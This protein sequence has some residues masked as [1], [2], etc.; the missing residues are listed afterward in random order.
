M[1]SWLRSASK[2]D[3]NEWNK[4]YPGPYNG[5]F[6][7][8]SDDCAKKYE[9][10]W[11]PLGIRTLMHDHTWG[12]LSAFRR[13]WPKS[14]LDANGDLLFD[15]FEVVS[16]SPGSPADGN[17]Q[18]G[19]LLIAMDGDLFRTALALR[20]QA[21]L[22]KFQETRGLE[23]DAGEKLD[24][25][26][27]RGKVSFDVIRP[28]AEGTT[29]TLNGK[30]V[31]DLQVSEELR[32]KNLEAEIDVPVTPG[33][34]IV[35]RMELTQ[36]GNGSCG[37]EFIR[38][39][40]EGSGGTMDLSAQRRISEANGWGRIRNGSEGEPI[41]YKGKEVKEAI[42]AHAPGNLGWVV[43]EGY[44]RFR[45]TVVA[46]A[47]AAGFKIR[48]QGRAV[49]RSLPD[50]Y[51][52]THR[53]VSFNI[54]KIGSYTRAMPG[55]G[56]AKS[57]TVAKMTAAWLASQQQ[58]DGSWKRTCGYTHNGYDTAWAGLGL[59][60]HGDPAYD[61][62]I[63][64]AAHFIA[65]RCPQDGWAVPSSVM[66]MFLSEYWLRTKDNSILVPLQSQ[67]E[68]IQSEM[69]YGDWNGGHGLNP[70]YGGS[71]V[72]TGGSHIT[73]ALAVANLTPVKVEA[74][75]VDKMLARAQE[76]GPDG[77]IPYGRATGTRKFVP[78]LDGAG[79]YSGRHAPYLVASL[80][81]GG[82]RLFTQNCKAM[83]VEGPLGGIDQGHATQSLS[84]TWALMATAIADPEA[85]S[86]HMAA[87]RWKLTMLRNVDGGFGWNAYRLEYQGGEGLLPNYLRSG[88]Y[89]MVLNAHKRNLAMTGSPQ[90]QAKTLPDLPPVCHGDAVALG[91][92]QRNWGVVD[93]MLG[94]KS[95]VRLKDGLKRLL[96]MGKTKDTHGE[97]YTFLKAEAAPVAKELLALRE[98][99]VLQKQYFAEMVMGVDI[100]LSVE[101]ERKDDKEVPGSWQVQMDAQHPL[102]GY[103]DGI[104]AKD[105][106]AWRKDSPLPM[107]GKVEIVDTAGKSF[108]ASIPINKDCGNND[109]QTRSEKEAVS[110]PAKGPLPLIA[111][112]RYTVGSMKFE[113]DRPIIAGGE[114]AGNG[115]KG[116]KLLGDRVVW[117][118]GRLMR[119]LGGWNASFTLSSGQFIGTATQGVASTILEGEK[120]WVSPQA[121]TVAAGTNCEFG[122]SSGWQPWEAR[123]AAIRVG[124]SNLTI[125]PQKL[126]AG[127]TTLDRKA[128]EDKDLATVQKLSFPG[129]ADETLKVEA[130]FAAATPVRGIDLRVKKDD[131]L[132]M[133]VEADINGRWQVV[134]QGRPGDRVSAFPSVTTKKLRVQLMYLEKNPKEVEIEELRVIRAE[135]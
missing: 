123:V 85:L 59:L 66:V 132:R 107:E 33:Q 31:Q 86:R 102:A 2:I 69:V 54:P 17:L 80:I 55:G 82:P 93:S 48:V 45:T 90:W 128:M 11:G 94:A 121:G 40:F 95:P 119:D 26:E 134:F 113:Y 111:R 4:R 83:Y 56:D 63:R 67:I 30:M 53:V 77:F 61:S 14:L 79:T 70:G 58:E 34:E 1:T 38:P 43:P 47:A 78:N 75:L 8:D 50:A 3:H 108:A 99:D 51:A 32:G 110:N 89:L 6:S 22:M 13:A 39:R 52:T 27:G 114:E 120:K 122:F 88:C 46:N 42:W 12:G 98:V 62:N 112:V 74:G 84:M 100:R 41:K 68:R 65:F 135:S 44:T 115:E 72:S 16:V 103:F 105:R 106:E 101:P 71:G 21:P 92:Y 126:I 133:M 29:P 116:R 124:G 25:A 19:D 130:E 87:M 76:L 49:P 15:C 37:A 97:L 91:Y 18:K 20:P 57:V 28:S 7:P 5:W 36:G 35:V 118:K 64:K 96:A 9:I 117:V 129:Q 10:T 125:E 60:A 24:R 81:H 73:L 109:W 104:E 127:T 131:G 23:M